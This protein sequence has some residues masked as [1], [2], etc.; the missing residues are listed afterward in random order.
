M[1]P[2]SRFAGPLALL[3]LGA[4]HAMA[5]EADVE[6]Q[7]IGCVKPLQPANVSGEQADGTVRIDALV[8]ADGRISDTKIMKSSGIRLIDRSSAYILSCDYS[9]ARRNGQAQPGWITLQYAWVLDPP[10]NPGAAAQVRISVT[11]L[12]RA[13]SPISTPGNSASDVR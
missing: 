7:L 3:A 4:G 8:R 2:I 1:W 9:P 11:Q 5:Q 10:A 6:A 13:A 12:S